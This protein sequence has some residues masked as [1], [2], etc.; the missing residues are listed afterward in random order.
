MKS[1]KR[2][3]SRKRIISVAEDDV[4][5]LSITVAV[6]GTGGVS[7]VIMSTEDSPIKWQ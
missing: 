5:I 1:N 2:K 7:S 4:E 3:R 6:K